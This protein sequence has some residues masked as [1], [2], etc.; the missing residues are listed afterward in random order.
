MVNQAEAVI[1]YPS[2]PSAS[3]DA[4]TVAFGPTQPPAPIGE[5]PNSAVA[6]APLAHYPHGA[7]PDE[8]TLL[9]ER[10]SP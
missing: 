9:H 7:A 2:P 1:S 5:T 10:I 4:F 3:G 8:L 6:E